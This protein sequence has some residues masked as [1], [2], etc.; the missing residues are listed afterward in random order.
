MIG[1]LELQY[2]IN[3]TKYVQYVRKLRIILK[4]LKRKLSLLCILRGDD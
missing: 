4:G 2:I 3:V 1:Y